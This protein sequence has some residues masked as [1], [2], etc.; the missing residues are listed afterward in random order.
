V[1]AEHDSRRGAPFGLNFDLGP[2]SSSSTPTNISGLRAGLAEV[3]DRAGDMWGEIS[4]GTMPPGKAG[5]RPDQEWKTA[6]GKSAGLPGLGTDTGKATVRNWLACG[7]PIVS[8]VTGAVSDASGLGKLVDPPK[9]GG[10]GAKTF[11]DIYP[12]V[13]QGCSTSCH[14]PTGIKV[15]LD[16]TSK[17][18]TIKSLVD[19]AP[20]V[21]DEA[22]CSTQTT[23]LIVAGSCKDSLVYKKLK[24]NP[25]CGSQMPIGQP[26]PDSSIQALCDWIDAGAK[27]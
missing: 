6:D 20:H 11:D 8:G 19:K 17:D 10:T 22:M 24:P 5:E 7:A 21:G 1:Y 27:Q 2:L 9:G 25:P 3:H 23:K 13:F 12:L 26:L 14:N 18:A 16:F 4:G 15:G